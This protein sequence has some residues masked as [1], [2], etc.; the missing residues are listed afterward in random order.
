[1]AVLGGVLALVG[2]GCVSS[3]T[4]LGVMRVAGSAGGAVGTLPDGSLIIVFPPTP[5]GQGGFVSDVQRF[6]LAWNAGWRGEDVLTAVAVSIA[7]NP[8]GDPEVISSTQDVGLWQINIPTWAAQFGGVQALMVPGNN[9]DA[10]FWIQQHHGWS[11][12]T[13]Y[14]LGL[15]Q[16]YMAR[17]AAAAAV[18]ANPPNYV[19]PLPGWTGAVSLHWGVASGGSDLFAPRG[20]PIRSV[21]NGVVQVAGYDSI[22]GNAV[23][24]RGTDGLLYYYAHLDALPMVAARQQVRAGDQIGVVGN[25]GDAVNTP[26]HLHIGIGYSILLGMDAYGGTGAGFDAVTFLRQLYASSR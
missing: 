18:A 6:N 25:T 3:M 4:F 14:R 22:G 23:L 17:A 21:S 16:Q 11:Q 7:E 20:W 1:M 2:S 15:H 8:A 19:F 24:I 13:T 26:T 9:A 5:I 12:W 10:A